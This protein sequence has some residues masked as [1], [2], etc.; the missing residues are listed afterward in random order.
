MEQVDKNKNNSEVG[1]ALK[2]DTGSVSAGLAMQL[3][4]CTGLIP[5][6]GDLADAPTWIGRRTNPGVSLCSASLHLCIF[7]SH[8]VRESSAAV[9]V[10]SL[11]Q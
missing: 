9:C 7:A 5:D 10:C 3:A 8:V 6:Q 11:Q 4:L 1:E 2:V